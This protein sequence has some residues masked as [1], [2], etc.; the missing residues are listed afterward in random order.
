MKV[1]KR[2]HVFLS[3]VLCISFWLIDCILYCSCWMTRLDSLRVVSFFFSLT[4]ISYFLFTDTVVRRCKLWVC[5]LS[6]DVFPYKGADPEFET[7]C[8]ETLTK[9]IEFVFLYCWQFTWAVYMYY[10]HLPNPYKRGGFSNLRKKP[11]SCCFIHGILE[12]TL[13]EVKMP[14]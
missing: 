12:S 13:K 4:R 2:R 5:H 1:I 11:Y 7:H 9:V 6:L 8:S 14:N 3:F 10:L